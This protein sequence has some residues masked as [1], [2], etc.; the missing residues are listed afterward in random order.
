MHKAREGFQELLEVAGR[1]HDAPSVFAANVG[2]ALVL[3]CLAELAQARE[4]L[5][6]V[7]ALVELIP[8][9]ST[10]QTQWVLALVYLSW[11]LWLLGFPDQ[12]LKRGR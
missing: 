7:L 10:W 5:E 12:A 11:T 2:M 3:Y 4:R 9:L 1:I 6:Q 8:E